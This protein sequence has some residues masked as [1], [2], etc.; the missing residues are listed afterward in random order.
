VRTFHDTVLEEGSVPLDVLE[1]HV[2][3]WIGKQ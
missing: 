3:G 2:R 1:G